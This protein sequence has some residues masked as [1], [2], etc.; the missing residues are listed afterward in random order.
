MAQSLNLFS[1]EDDP[2]AMWRE[3]ANMLMSA[4]WAGAQRIV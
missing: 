4:N 1:T 3:V 2:T